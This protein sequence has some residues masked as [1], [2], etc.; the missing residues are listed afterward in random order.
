ME[1]EYQSS[2]ELVEK[3]LQL[4]S[5]AQVDEAGRLYARCQEDVG[6]LLINK[7]PENKKIQTLLAKMFFVSKD[8]LKAALVFENTGELEKAA[9][10]YEKADDYAMAAEMFCQAGKYAKG[11]AMFE[12][13]GN[14]EQAATFF[15][16]EGLL[17]R[18]A[19]NFEKAINNYLAG[20]TY[21]Q[22]GKYDKA[23]ELLQKVD[24]NDYT[25][26]QATLMIGGI[27]SNQGFHDLAIRKYLAVIQSQGFND[28]TLDVYYELAC[29]YEHT[30]QKADA[31]EIFEKILTYKF[32]YKDVASR[33]K[34]M[35]TSDVEV[36]E[37][38]E[39]ATTIDDA[40]ILEEPSDVED[41]TIEE[42]P[43]SGE[44]VSMLDGIEFL[45]DT[46][47][48]E[49][50][51][52]QEMKLFYVGFD[53]IE[54]PA[55]QV[56]IEQD[57]IGKAFYLLITGSVVVER[58]QEGRT[59]VLATLGPGK[60]FGEMSLMDENAVTSAR[61][62]TAEDCELLS[63]SREQFQLLLDSHDRLALKVYKAFTRTMMDRLR[64]TNQA[65][66]NY[67]VQKEKELANLF[68]S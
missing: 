45:K 12:K 35:N 60:F 47:L 34:K 48:F 14:H 30:G 10:L 43:A 22:L 23:M 61:V 37:V 21:Y 38:I 27:L 59:D 63:M 8:F 42:H 58:D 17:E 67:K 46:P 55:G 41:A 19:T 7:M 6:F 66:T 13:A 18:A 53:T 2:I 31:Q 50:L 52:L 16:Q 28:E 51:S 5:T 29:L 1:Q 40:N 65:L 9:I 3:L 24:E 20:K 4:V 44:I 57:V 56:L 39:E 64:Q 11:A 33:L 49:D 62:K 26:L 36:I 32:G 15:E 54:V 25:F 68:G